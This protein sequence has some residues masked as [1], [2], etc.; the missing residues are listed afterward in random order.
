M[1]FTNITVTGTWKRAD[2]SAAEGYVLAKLSVPLV[3]GAAQADV[4]P[5]RGAL[6]AKG[7]LKSQAEAPFVLVANDDTGTEPTG[8]SYQFTL[9]LDGEPPRSFYSPLTHVTTPVDLSELE[10][11]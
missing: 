7:E 1:A 8:S 3:N 10:E 11:P 4:A 5:I 9:L 2:G 6:N